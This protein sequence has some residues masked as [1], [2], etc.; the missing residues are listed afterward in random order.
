[1]FISPKIVVKDSPAHGKGVFSI[2]IIISGEVIE[3]CHFIH[4][5]EP[6]F[7]KM[8]SSLKE[9]TFSWP[10]FTNNSHAVVLGYGSIYNHR[11]D[12]NAT[13]K[14]DLD[15]KCYTFIAIKDIQPGEEIFTNYMR[16]TSF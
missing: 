9:Y 1:M 8:D 4:L 5:S 15:K 14:T 3:E 7:T 10:L 16:S 6:D 11:D 13:W 12:N 2:D